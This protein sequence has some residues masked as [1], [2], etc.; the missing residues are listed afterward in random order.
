MENKKELKPRLHFQRFEF[1]Y[2][3]PDKLMSDIKKDLLKNNMK[4]DAHLKK[5]DTSY[6]VRSLYYDSPDLIRNLYIS[7]HGASGLHPCTW[8]RI[9][10]YPRGGILSNNV[11]Y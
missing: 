8:T 11:F 4:W 1:K 6:E 10:K 2:F 7:G 9:Q 3:L 5:P